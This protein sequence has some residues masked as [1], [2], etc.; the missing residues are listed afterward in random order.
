MREERDLILED[1]KKILSVVDFRAFKNKRVL[2]TGAN[3]HI[4]QY[5]V[6][7]L[8]AANQTYRLNCHITCVSL[9]GPGEVIS[10]YLPDKHMTFKKIDLTKPFRLSGKFD[11]IFH[12]A[13]YGRPARFASDP[14]G[15][16]A[17][18]V[19]ATKKLL[20]ISERSR[21]TFVFFSSAEVYGEMPPQ[22][23]SFKEEFAGNAIF[24][25][26]PRAIYATSKR[27]GEALVLFFNK[28][29]GVRARIVRIS[30]VYGPGTPI[31]DSYVMSDF[32]RKALFDR[33]ITL[34]DAGTSVRT[35]GYIADVVAMILHV[36]LYGEATIYNVGGR[37]TVSIRE[38]AKK[39]GAALGVEARVPRTASKAYFVGR[40][41]KR[42]KLNLSK[43][44]KEMKKLSFTSFRVGLKNTVAWAQHLNRGIE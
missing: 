5:L 14:Y 1:C 30:V 44:K 10:R 24:P 4:G 8:H 11:Y 23:T 17:T 32:I 37:D 16:I 15:T 19:E 25:D 42:V 38:L 20:E 29:R 21:G 28:H 33:R 35:Y 36:A 22:M 34:L 31:N 13:G 12:A 7:A 26:G 6:S 41:P 2:I 40:D 9:H 3:G 39:I 27:L 18:N 43:I